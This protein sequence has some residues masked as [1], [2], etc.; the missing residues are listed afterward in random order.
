M[1]EILLGIG[2][3]FIGVIILTLGITILRFLVKRGG[4][5]RF[6]AGMDSGI[7]VEHGM[8]V[9]RETGLVTPQKKPSTQAFSHLL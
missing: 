2:G 1:T 8:V 5:A 7:Y 9:D 4:I 3:I 6:V